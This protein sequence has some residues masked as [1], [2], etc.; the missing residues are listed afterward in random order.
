MSS[1]RSV[2][3]GGG[4]GGGAG[5]GTGAGGV[6]NQQLSAEE[7]AKTKLCAFLSRDDIRETLQKAQELRIALDNALNHCP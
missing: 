6:S 7:E 1:V 4:A 2:G 5:A 3:G